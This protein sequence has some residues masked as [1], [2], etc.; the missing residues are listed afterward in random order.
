VT[1]KEWLICVAIIL[2]V[3]VLMLL[4]G[5]DSVSEET[6][7]TAGEFCEQALNHKLNIEVDWKQAQ[8]IQL[9]TTSKYTNNDGLLFVWNDPAV[10]EEI[11]CT[12]SLKTKEIRYLS[13]GGE[14]LTNLIKR[15]ER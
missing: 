5:D 3:G 12:T 13:I 11:K 7:A 4:I 14:N 8:F 6:K 2:P 10:E 1:L 9:G 15:E